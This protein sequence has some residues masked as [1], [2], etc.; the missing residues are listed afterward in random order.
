MK[1]LAAVRRSLSVALLLYGST[2]FGEA[3]AVAVLYPDVRE[4]YRAVFTNLVEGIRARVGP[5]LRTYSVSDPPD[6]ADLQ[7][8]FDD[9][10]PDAIIALGKGGLSA[11]SNLH[12]HVPVVAGALLLLPATEEP[13]NVGVSLAADPEEI[14]SRL[15]WLVP[16][17]KRIFVV[18]NPQQNAWLIG[19]AKRAAARHAIELVSYPADDLHAAV[20]HY[21]EIMEQAGGSTDSVWLPLDSTTVDDRVILPLVLEAAWDK[22][23]VVFSSNPAHAQRGAL[24]SVYPDNLALGGRLAEIAVRLEKGGDDSSGIIVPLKDLKLAV[25]LRTADHLGL[26]FSPGQQRKFGLV[27]P[28]P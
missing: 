20:V 11:V 27:F 14:F 23:F 18:Y 10:R 8:W 28:S 25:N 15:K 6:L 9:Q 7:R 19:L 16:E 12:T 17:V 5:R 26:Q 13:V 2:V 4:P 22:R 24:F 1:P 21:R 3:A